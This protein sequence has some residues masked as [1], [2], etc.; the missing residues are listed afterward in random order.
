MVEEG[1]KFKKER[2]TEPFSSLVSTPPEK[3][4]EGVNILKGYQRTFNTVRNI[5]CKLQRC[6]VIS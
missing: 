4:G 3:R 2:E 1:K 6:F 5:K